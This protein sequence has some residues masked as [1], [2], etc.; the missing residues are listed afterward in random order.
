MP[1]TAADNNVDEWSFQLGLAIGVFAGLL[2][3]TMFGVL[4][5]RTQAVQA[6]ECKVAVV[7]IARYHEA[8]AI[9]LKYEREN[10]VC[11]TAAPAK[12]CLTL[13]VRSNGDKQ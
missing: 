5:W 9:E 3:G 1:K 10:P 11:P 12:T 13:G 2:F 4:R 7:E 6:E 8:C